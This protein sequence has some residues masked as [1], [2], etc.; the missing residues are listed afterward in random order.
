MRREALVFFACVLAGAL[1]FLLWNIFGEKWEVPADGEHYLAMYH[2]KPVNTPFAYRIFTPTVARLLP[3]S[4]PSNF[5]VVTGVSLALAS[6]FLGLH[7]FKQSSSVWT[8]WLACLLWCT[9]FPLVY[10]GTTHIR[11]DAPMLAML[12][13]V[14][15]LGCYRVPILVIAVIVMLGILSHE[16]MLVC[17]A[18]FL[19][20]KV[21]NDDFT[22]TRPYSWR[23]LTLLSV[24]ALVF[25]VVLQRAIT[26]DPVASSY[27]GKGIGMASDVLHYSGGPIRH[28]L[29]IFSA[30]GPALLYACFHAAPWKS[31][32]R[33]FTL[34][35]LFILAS[36]ATL[37]ATDTLRVM[38][39]LYPLIFL[40]AASFMLEPMKRGDWGSFTLL[41]LLQLTYS[42]LVFGHLRTFE[43]SKTM[44]LGAA[45]VAFLALLIA[46][47][48]EF[49][50]PL[51]SR[52]KLIRGG[53]RE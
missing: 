22:G 35:G 10:Y 42:G 38:S 30:Y 26:A 18:T 36:C 48:V 31:K 53:L 17:V 32:A 6:G 16:T 37:L 43:K 8:S 50:G 45:G 39:I 21:F 23:A 52:L 33:F 28:L 19:A 2:G 15:C 25:L 49:N 47:K 24:S 41:L 1:G 9:S 3:W 27:S 44:F 51:R 11:A 34:C 29:R 14:Y 12:A 7:T 40:H 4:P 13:L 46:T 5:A 20:A